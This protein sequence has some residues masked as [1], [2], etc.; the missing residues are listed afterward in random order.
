MPAVVPR[1]RPK[2]SASPPWGA[3]KVSL[4][5][6]L[7]RLFVTNN[8]P[9]HRWAIWSAIAPLFADT[10]VCAFAFVLQCTPPAFLWDKTIQP[11]GKCPLPINPFAIALGAAG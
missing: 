5:L 10:L 6:L 3:A 8:N 11:T 7:L 4:D 2:S 1:H 9:W